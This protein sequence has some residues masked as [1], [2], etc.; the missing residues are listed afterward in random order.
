MQHNIPTGDAVAREQDA[1]DLKQAKHGHEKRGADER[2]ST[3]Q[4]ETKTNK[5]SQKKVVP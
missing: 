5:D 4:S 3:M 1:L 2:T